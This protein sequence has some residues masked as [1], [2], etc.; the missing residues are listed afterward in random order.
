MFVGLESDM[1]HLPSLVTFL[2]HQFVADLLKPWET[3]LDNLIEVSSTG[4][5]VSLEPVCAT[6]NEQAL[7][8][9]ENGRGIV[10]ME[11]LQSNIHE[12]GPLP[13]EIEVQDPLDQLEQLLSNWA[14]RG[15]ENGEDTIAEALLLIFVNQGVVGVV[16]ASGP[17]SVCAVLEIDDGC[18]GS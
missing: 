9:G 13:G 3:G 15:G 4:I 7:E 14:T 2:V 17:A 12:A 6:S 10:G 8:S 5:M 18:R 16:V 1:E 11:Q